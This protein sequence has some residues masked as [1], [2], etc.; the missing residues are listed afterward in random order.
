MARFSKQEKD[1]V[2]AKADAAGLSI[3]EYIRATSMGEGY[4]PPTNPELTK[5]ILKLNR[6]L[7]AQGNNL[8]QI[9]HHLNSGQSLP[10]EGSSLLAIISRSMLQTHKAVRDALSR[11]KTPEP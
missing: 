2:E 9:A 6:E 8:N 5:A 3:N 11:G 4:K 1:S 7:T 10:A